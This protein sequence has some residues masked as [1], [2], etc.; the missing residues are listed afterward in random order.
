MKRSILYSLFCISQILTS[1]HKTTSTEAVSRKPHQAI[2]NHNNTN[3][4]D[5]KSIEE[6]LISKS[7]PLHLAAAA[8]SRPVSPVIN[9]L[10]TTT[11]LHS[12]MSSNE[13]QKAQQLDDY[14]KT[15]QS[16]HSTPAPSTAAAATATNTADQQFH[17]QITELQIQPQDKS[18]EHT[19]INHS[20]QTNSINQLAIQQAAAA[21]VAAVLVVEGYGSPLSQT[22]VKKGHLR[23]K[24]KR[25]FYRR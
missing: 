16:H 14:Q 24:K 18:E 21:A 25:T 8:I 9:P 2:T 6:I 17:A 13:Q 7:I 3:P 22:K 12:M 5:T 20:T 10:A 19:F 15:E 23:F 11:A 1:A 4:E